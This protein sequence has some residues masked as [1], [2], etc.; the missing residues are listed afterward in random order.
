MMKPEKSA[1]AWI[2]QLMNS[3][4]AFSL[5]A[6]AVFLTWLLSTVD[7]VDKLLVAVHLREPHL[8][9]TES[10]KRS[11]F[12]RAFIRSAWLRLY[13]MRRVL[14][15]QIP[16][17]PQTAKDKEW[18]SYK[19]A[20]DNWN[21]DLMIN[22]LSFQ[23]FY[24]DGKRY[25]FENI[26]QPT[27][28]GIHYCLESVNSPELKLPCEISNP[29]DPAKLRKALDLLNVNLYCFASGLD[30]KGQRCSVKN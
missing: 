2:E 19:V 15:V 20:L 28:A 5:G 4:I 21:A 26:L 6:I 13:L 3:K 23:Q 17:Y 30:E 10:D 29:P 18:D 25:E 9:V 24:G 1:F 22:I 11:E 16:G 7:T 8:A 27:F 12:S 14:M